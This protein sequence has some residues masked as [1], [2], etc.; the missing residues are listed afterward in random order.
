MPN[1][2]T[3]R[4][5]NGEI[6][7]IAPGPMQEMAAGNGVNNVPSDS[8]PIVQNAS[9]SAPAT[10]I[11]YYPH[12]N[13]QGMTMSPQSNDPNPNQNVLHLRGQ[14][15]ESSPMSLHRQLGRDHLP[16]SERK[17]SELWDSPNNTGMNLT[18]SSSS[19]GVHTP[20]RYYGHG[21]SLKTNKRRHHQQ[22]SYY[23]KVNETH[24]RDD[25]GN[26]STS[27]NP[28]KGSKITW[29]DTLREAPSDDPVFSRKVCRVC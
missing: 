27:T 3:N 14:S 12:R 24:L 13:W 7:V 22:Q 19:V 6:A 5:R 20:P 28:K 25:D 18:S 1:N 4:N 26:V 15:V 9:I 21:W 16:G 11:R 29:N 2:T 17:V 8:R 23:Y 10:P